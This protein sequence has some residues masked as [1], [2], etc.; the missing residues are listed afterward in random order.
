MPIAS[1]E[2]ETAREAR[3]THVVAMLNKTVAMKMK[4]KPAKRAM[5]A[6]AS[7]AAAAVITDNA[8]KHAAAIKPTA[9]IQVFRAAPPPQHVCTC[10][11]ID[12]DEEEE[13]GHEPNSFLQLFAELE[14]DVSDE[15]YR[16]LKDDL[17]S[18]DCLQDMA[19]IAQ[20]EITHIGRNYRD[21]IIAV[22]H[23]CLV[24][25]GL[26]VHTAASIVSR[27]FINFHLL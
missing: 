20:A 15:I 26:D 27:V 12:I 8:D 11:I 17:Q 22:A 10:C 18:V 23:S 7:A 14:S 24:L 19:K 25:R 9:Q 2:A 5:M 13:A 21:K 4:A 1:K 16:N 6:K 3:H